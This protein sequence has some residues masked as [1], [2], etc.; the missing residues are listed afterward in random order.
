MQLQE[1]L[2][3]ARASIREATRARDAAYEVVADHEKTIRNFREHARRVQDQNADL[4][5]RLERETDRPAAQQE[6]EPVQEMLSFKAVFEGTRA[7]SRAV[8]MELRACEERQSRRHAAYLASYLGDAFS[9]RGG[10]GDA[11]ALLLLVPRAMSKADILIAQVR[12]T[13]AAPLGGPIDADALLK[14]HGVE[15]HAYGVCLIHHLD[16]LAALLGRFQS[17]LNSC[18]PEVFLRVG[19]CQPEMSVHERAVDFYVELLKKGQLDENVPL[20]NLE[21][22]HNYFQQIYGMYL[23]SE[24]PDCPSFLRAHVKA[25]FSA[26]EALSPEVSE[27]S[28]ERNTTLSKVSKKKHILLLYNIGSNRWL[29]AT[30]FSRKA[31]AIPRPAPF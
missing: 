21:K 16:S 1:D 9:R 23:E 13:L 7:H 18:S 26:S 31:V 24:K 5:A 8:E 27:L 3:L 14:G 17:A 10:D 4:R 28:W 22:G 12:E 6:V 20:D 2:D 25:F 19:S 11:V 29:S 15:K 30:C